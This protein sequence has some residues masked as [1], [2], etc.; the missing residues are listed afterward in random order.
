MRNEYT[1]RLDKFKDN[2][3]L[4]MPWDKESL[5][6]F[7]KFRNKIAHDQA[8][9]GADDPALSSP[10]ILELATTLSEQDWQEMLGV[11]KKTITQLDSAVSKHV[12]TDYGCAI[13]VFRVLERQA[14][15]T[16]SELRHAVL[17]E[18]RIP[19]PHSGKI[20]IVNLVT[21]MGYEVGPEDILRRTIVDAKRKRRPANE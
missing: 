17:N 7:Q 19:A 3:A 1:S 20:R 6:R 16:L 4:T 5:N 15:V 13:A 9:D 10:E 18:W 2:F 11:F 12:A 21:N 14:A 8:L